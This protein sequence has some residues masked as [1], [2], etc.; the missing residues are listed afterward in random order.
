M[1]KSYSLKIDYNGRL[2]GSDVL[3]SEPNE[4]SCKGGE[5]FFTVKDKKIFNAQYDNLTPEIHI[6][7]SQK[8]L[9]AFKG[10]ISSGLIDSINE[11][12]FKAHV[13]GVTFLNST[14]NKYFK[15]EML[16]EADTGLFFDY[17][18]WD[19]ETEE[20]PACLWFHMYVL[21]I[22]KG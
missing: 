11:N 17:R 18:I 15:S 21:K 4:F 9:N 5:N 7:S 19:V 13:Y 8:E 14:G 12:D 20:V 2:E 6:I 16:K 1:V 22:R 3:G 10:V